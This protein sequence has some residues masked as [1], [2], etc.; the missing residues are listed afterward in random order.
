MVT[1]TRGERIVVVAVPV[2]LVET[3]DRLAHVDPLG[4]ETAAAQVDPA[5]TDG[6]RDPAEGLVGLVTSIGDIGPGAQRPASL[7][8]EDL[9]H[10]PHGV[11]TVETGMRAAHDLDALDLGERQELPGNRARGHGAHA[12]TVDHHEHVVRIGTA[13]EHRADLAERTIAR[14]VQAVDL[15]QQLRERHRAAAANV[16]ARDDRDRG[17]GLIRGLRGPGGRDDD[18]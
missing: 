14:H 6:A 5:A 15:A 2:R 17:Q 10:P 9:D 4:P 18:R 7:A 13:Q 12:H 1:G 16:R 8:R 11:G 3:Q